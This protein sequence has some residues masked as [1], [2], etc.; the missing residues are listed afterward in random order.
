MAYLIYPILF[1]VICLSSFNI[2]PP[3]EIDETEA[4]MQVFYQIGANSGYKEKTFSQE[5]KK[6][7]GQIPQPEK[8]SEEKV[9]PEIEII[10]KTV[11]YNQKGD[12]VTNFKDVVLN[13]HTSYEINLNGL[14]ENYTPPK[15]KDSVQIL[16]IHT[17]ATEGYANT[18]DNRTTDVKN[19]MIEIG[20]VFSKALKEKGFNVVHDVKL[21]DYPSYNGSYANSLKTMNWYMEHY[22]D[23]DIVFDLHRDAVG[24]G[25]TKT[26]FVTDINGM[27]VAQ[28]MLVVGTNEGGLSHDTWK[29]NL[30]FAAGLQSTADNIYPSLMRALD[31]RR[32]RFNQSV[33]KQSIIV[34][35][36]SNGNT[37]EEAKASGKLLADVIYSYIK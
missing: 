36:G 10:E 11:T 28:L 23:I 21:H 33:T 7:V 26:K 8:M 16:V 34:E 37:I 14:M 12:S 9:E 17:H 15:R 3:V 6:I 2:V 32:E 18:K 22:P 20:D 5:I 31:L 24:D 19:N 30:K 1:C 29:E 27:K 35:V 4:I 13:N 25:E